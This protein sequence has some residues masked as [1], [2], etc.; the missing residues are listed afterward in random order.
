MTRRRKNRK[1]YKS[2]IRLNRQL[3][4]NKLPLKG[5]KIKITRT[6]D[7]QQFSCECGY[8]KLSSIA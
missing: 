4:T 2:T 5:K 3:G 8:D 1:N 7:N 6:N